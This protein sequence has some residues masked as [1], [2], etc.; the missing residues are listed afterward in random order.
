MG[1]PPGISA[2]V[3]SRFSCLERRDRP[4][5]TSHTAHAVKR[6]MH[7]NVSWNN[8]TQ[9]RGDYSSFLPVLV[10]IFFKNL[11]LVFFSWKYVGYALANHVIATYIGIA[12]PLDCSME[13][14][15]D[16]RCQSFNCAESG[17]KCELNDQRRE[18]RPSD[19]GTRENATYFGPTPQQVSYKSFNRRPYQVPQ[20]PTFK[21]RLR[22]K[23]F[24]RKWVSFA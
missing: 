17:N 4:L 12:C 1:V 24:M 16:V 13:C 21:A 2:S 7:V 5:L 18:T 23:P 3:P 10:I 15:A 9:I 11:L 20:T 14:V 6:L 8:L 22:A 19:F